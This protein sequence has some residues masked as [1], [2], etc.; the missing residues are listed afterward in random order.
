MYNN[1]KF[2]RKFTF[3]MEK[4]QFTSVNEDFTNE[5]NKEFGFCLAKN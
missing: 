4:A 3:N 2:I 1:I 5:H